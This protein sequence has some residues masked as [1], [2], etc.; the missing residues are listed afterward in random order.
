MQMKLIV[1]PQGSSSGRGP[2]C[3]GWF[4]DY[5]AEQGD[6]TMQALTLAGGIKGW[7]A[8]GQEYVA[9]VQG[10]DGEYWKQFVKDAPPGN[11]QAGLQSSKNT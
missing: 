1:F 6:S 2:R 7:V 11:A 3:S 5:I 4:A 10:Y 9:A 8:A